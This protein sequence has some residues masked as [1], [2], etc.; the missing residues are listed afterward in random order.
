VD[1]SRI[2]PRLIAI[3]DTM[4]APVAALLGRAEVLLSRALP[5]SVMLQLRDR[6]LTDRQ[7]LTLGASLAEL[8][9]RY[10]QYF[11]VNDRLDLALLLAAH[12]VHLGEQSLAPRD[13]RR[14]VGGRWISRAWHDPL[15]FPE[16][17]ADAL[18]LS[19]VMKARKSNPALGLDGLRAARSRLSARPRDVPGLYAL[20]GIDAGNARDCLEAG[21]DGIA[22]LSAV[23]GGAEPDAL[24]DALG[25]RRS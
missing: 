24:L 1:N 16:Q 8:A 4:L 2:K 6:Q 20:G 15:H 19:P 12:G 10:E 18:L 9:R 22:A 7:R 25:V 5:G 17:G 3:T 14:I 13:A 23:F 11:V 21:A